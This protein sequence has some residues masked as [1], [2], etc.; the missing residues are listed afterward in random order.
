MT[1]SVHH[2]R[3]LLQPNAKSSSQAKIKAVI[4]CCQNKCHIPTAAEIPQCFYVVFLRLQ[5]K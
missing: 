4:G 5:R 1:L 3:L 2:L